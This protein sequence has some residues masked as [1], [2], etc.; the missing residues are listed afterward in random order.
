[1]CGTSSTLPAVLVAST[2]ILILSTQC[3]RPSDEASARAACE[4]EATKIHAEA[5]PYCFD[6]LECVD[7]IIARLAKPG[8]IW[9]KLIVDGCMASKGH[10]TRKARPP[11][12]GGGK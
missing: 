6:T 12:R 8:T 5:K 2:V 7:I 1:M 9:R 4:A 3:A 11:Q 10:I